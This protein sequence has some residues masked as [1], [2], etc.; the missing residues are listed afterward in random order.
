M[1]SA[2]LL[3]STLTGLYLDRN[4]SSVHNITTNISFARLYTDCLHSRLRNHGLKKVVLASKLWYRIS[5]IAPM[6]AN[7]GIVTQAKLEFEM[8]SCGEKYASKRASA[9]SLIDNMLKN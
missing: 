2:K 9:R 6:M 8:F 7:T 3:P 1:T 4:R 5:S